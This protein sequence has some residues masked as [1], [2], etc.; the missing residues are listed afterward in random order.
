[1][2]RSTMAEFAR[3]LDRNPAVDIGF[4]VG[5]DVVYTNDFGVRF[6]CSIIGFSNNQDAVEVYLNK[7]SYWYPISP[8][9]LQLRGPMPDGYFKRIGQ[10]LEALA[11]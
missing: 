11:D 6:E 9:Q 2:P 8:E 7:D 4:S 3:S 10:H 5:D 1:M